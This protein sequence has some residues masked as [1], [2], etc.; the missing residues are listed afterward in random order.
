MNIFVFG[1]TH[2]RIDLINDHAK[3]IITSTG[4]NPDLFIQ[5]GDFGVWHDDGESAGIIPKHRKYSDFPEYE[6]NKKQFIAPLIF[7][8]GNHENF[9]YLEKLDKHKSLVQISNTMYY[10][11][12]GQVINWDNVS[13]AGLGGCYAAPHYEKQGKQQGRF[14]RYIIKEYIDSLKNKRADILITHDSPYNT[15]PHSRVVGSPEITDLINLSGYKYVI[16]GHHHT[17]YESKIQTATG[18]A[19]LHGLSKEG[20][21]GFAKVIV[22]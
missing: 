11:K 13:I 20:Q 9:D 22:I 2:G 14:R 4:I 10:L 1:D 12:T 6:K 5:V 18:E 3:E 15:V 17:S 7:I 8:A 21:I 16:H 19:I